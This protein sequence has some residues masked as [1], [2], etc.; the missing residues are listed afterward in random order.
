MPKKLR[1]KKFLSSAYLNHKLIEKDLPAWAE[2]H[3]R[4]RIAQFIRGTNRMRELRAES[5]G[6]HLL[7]RKQRDGS[8]LRNK[9]ML[10]QLYVG[11]DDTL[12][13]NEYIA[14]WPI[15]HEYVRQLKELQGVWQGMAS[16][17]FE[18][19]E[20]KRVT[21]RGKVGYGKLAEMINRRIDRPV[22]IKLRN[23]S[24][25]AMVP[26]KKGKDKEWLEEVVGKGYDA[27]VDQE[28]ANSLLRYF[29]FSEDVIDELILESESRILAGKPPVFAGGK[30]PY[31]EPVTAAQVRA[32]LLTYRRRLSR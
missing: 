29:D 30:Y 31:D 28:D 26:Y 16:R 1:Q 7:F 8:E 20:L 10:L 25:A 24:V 32:K 11:I 21:S 23:E 2:L 27:S 3:E 22:R 13:K 9:G 12:T 6:V 18:M 4:N 17:F 15:V 14:N 19:L 5:H